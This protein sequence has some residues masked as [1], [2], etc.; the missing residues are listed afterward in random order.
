MQQFLEAGP[1]GHCGHPAV[2]V[3]EEA[4][5]FATEL[6]KIRLIA[7]IRMMGTAQCRTVHAIHKLAQ[8]CDV[9]QQQTTLQV[10][11]AKCRSVT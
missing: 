6:A 1:G 5:R 2:V 3:V 11:Q 8:V 9:I 7:E 4:R 10:F